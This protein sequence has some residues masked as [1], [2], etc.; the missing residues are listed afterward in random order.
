MLWNANCSCSFS[1]SAATSSCSARSRRA[2]WITSCRCSRLIGLVRKSAAPSRIACTAWSIVPK[3]VVMITSAGS[4]RFCTSSSSC[5]PSTRGIFRSVTIDAVG[6]LGQRL[7]RI[8]AVGG[9][10]H[11]RGRGRSRGRPGSACGPSRCPRRSGCVAWTR[12]AGPTGVVS[13]ARPRGSPYS[14]GC[15]SK[16][17]SCLGSRRAFRRSLRT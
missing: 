10:V 9:R 15:R 8:A 7:E 16:V 11:R 17:V 13:G 2:R 1:R 4:R 5:R 14:S 12:E 3:P 6:A